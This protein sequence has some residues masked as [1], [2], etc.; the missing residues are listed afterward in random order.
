M[1]C[2]DHEPKLWPL[3]NHDLRRIH[4]LWVYIL[5]VLCII[6]IIIIRVIF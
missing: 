6:I 3:L 2:F 1:H 5:W 4:Q